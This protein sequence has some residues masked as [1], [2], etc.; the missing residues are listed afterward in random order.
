VIKITECLFDS[1][2]S[3][4]RGSE[5]SLKKEDDIHGKLDSEYEADG[6][7]H[8]IGSFN[9]IRTFLERDVCI[10]HDGWSFFARLLVR[11]IFAVPGQKLS[12]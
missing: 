3:G 11:S 12:G 6:C 10:G 9:G 7:I 5:S 4:I 1:A 2:Y 8:Q